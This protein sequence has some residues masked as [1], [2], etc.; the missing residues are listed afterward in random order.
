M[1]RDREALRH[2]P[3]PCPDQ[4][5]EALGKMPLPSWGH[6][7]ESCYHLLG[8]SSSSSHRMIHTCPLL[9]TVFDL[10]RL[11]ALS[12]KCLNKPGILEAREEIPESVCPWPYL[13]QAPGVPGLSAP[14]PTQG[15]Q[16]PAPPTPT[17]GSQVSLSFVCSLLHSVLVSLYLYI[18]I[19]IL[20]HWVSIFL[21]CKIGIIIIINQFLRTVMRK[22]RDNY[23]ECLT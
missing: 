8:I 10:N 13:P 1:E 7:H 16:V 19:L 22:T 9:T 5:T 11:N 12:E 17:Q 21:T 2:P 18:Y 4:R 14:T 3:H 6:P 15:S 23:T 20:P